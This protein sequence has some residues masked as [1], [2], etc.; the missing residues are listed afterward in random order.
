MYHPCNA[1][2]LLGFS[3]AGKDTHAN[4]LVEECSGVVN[5]KFGAFNKHIVAKLFKVPPSMLDDH[6][7]RTTAKLVV[8]GR[9]TQVTAFDL[10][11]ALFRGSKGTVIEQEHLK[12]TRSMV[13]DCLPVFTDIRRVREFD[14]V[15]EDYNPLVIYLS[16]ND[17][18][19]GA[20]DF[21]I[22]EVWRYANGC[23]NVEPHILYV[24]D[25]ETIEE[26]H[27]RFRSL[28]DKYVVGTQ[29]K[30][31]LHIYISKSFQHALEETLRGALPTYEPLGKLASALAKVGVDFGI[32]KH[33]FNAMFQDAV[34][35]CDWKQMQLEPITTSSTMV[36]NDA[37]AYFLDRLREIA[38]LK[39]HVLDDEKQ[40]YAKLM[41]TSKELY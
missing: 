23:P 33:G 11:T 18:S 34:F 19:Q 26:T 8:D 15:L 7:W 5:A 14:A 24:N 4:M 2:V 22:G 31:T 32:D 1:I 37:H 27:T 28:V 30:P 10:L 3:G 25:V 20:N 29:T 35:N 12:H 41:F 17:V 40:E 13:G 9:I 6:T 21:E 39:V 36:W 16:R 38:D